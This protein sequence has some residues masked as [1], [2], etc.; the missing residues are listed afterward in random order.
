MDLAPPRAVLHAFARGW[1]TLLGIHLVFSIAA[2]TLAAPLAA[3]AIQGAV[4]VSGE[5]ALSD[6]AIAAFIFSPA[7]AVAAL[8]IGTLVLTLQLLGYATLLIP[9]RSLLKSGSCD[10]DAVLPLLLPALPRLLRI[11]LRFIVR[12]V[13]WSLP[14]IGLL[15]AVY[16]GLLGEHDINYYLAENPPVFRWA[17]ALASFVLLGHLMVVARVATG[18]IHALPLAIFRGES[19]DTAL[20]LSR[21]AA[22]GRRK[23]VFSGLVA[24][25]LLTPFVT[26]LL[27]LP[28]SA[29]AMLAARHLQDRLGWLVV[30]LGLCLALS[31]A[32]AW[33][34]AFCGLSLLALQNTRLYLDSGLDDKARPPGRAARRLPFG[35][36]SV[37]AGGL[38]GCGAMILLS[39]LWV[40]ALHEERPAVVIAHRGASAVAPENTLAAVREAVEA[41]ADWVE[42]DV[43]ESADGSV[44]V[45][46][47]SDFKRVGGP[48]RPI[49]ELRDAELA[50]ID[51]GTWKS[52]A[53]AAERVP[54]LADVLELCKDRSG[55]LIELKYYGHSQ[56]LEERVVGLVEAAGM[57]DQV[58]VMSLSHEGVRKIRQLRPDWKVGLLSSVA[59]GNVTKLD[60]DF[61][62]LNA[63][64]TSRKLV[65][66]AHKRG[67]Q[68][69]VW[70]VNDP[71][72]MSTMLG[73]GVDGL[74]TDHPALAREVLEERADA[75]IGEKLL[76]DL[77]GVLGK[78]PPTPQQ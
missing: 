7:G 41:G 76:I 5:S 35:W 71:V 13:L 6:T 9:C 74:I 68:V 52:P 3:A 17:L 55:V 69:H 30:V 51:I 31:T 15:G 59:V 24:W 37:I 45:F 27:N 77:A 22:T 39:H 26:W 18:W 36:K 64:T 2:G 42:I 25:G 11:S 67:V 61:L 46:H 12:L 29:V 53:F 43:Q 49:W 32:I 19:P 66:Q 78:K 47:D 8:A 16:A 62:G 40:E 38:A 23:V 10:D 65:R 54:L 72:D 60:L 75:S 70:T 1:K 73:R 63:R 50:A 28:W 44:F 56:R 20:R 14:F 4:L 21:E 48:A 58:M 57:A 33:L 34:A